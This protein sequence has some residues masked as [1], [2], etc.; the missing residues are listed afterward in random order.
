MKSNDS[1]CKQKRYKEINKTTF[2][3]G[4]ANHKKSKNLIN[5]KN[6]DT[7]SVE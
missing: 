3:K 5:Y 6:D 2:K 1:K 4:Y 7:L